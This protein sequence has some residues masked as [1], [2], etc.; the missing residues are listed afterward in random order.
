[1]VSVVGPVSLIE[2]AVGVVKFSS[3]FSFAGGIH[4]THIVLTVIEFH[5]HE[6]EIAIR[7]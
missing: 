6:L 5:P 2:R 1:M 3:T 7:R 4:L